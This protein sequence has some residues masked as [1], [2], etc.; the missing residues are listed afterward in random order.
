MIR[1]ERL[2]SII[3]LC[4]AQALALN[5][6]IAQ[7]AS[8]PPTA[9]QVAAAAA[10]MV[11]TDN[12]R[13]TT[14]VTV[15]NG[16]YVAGS[17]TPTAVT[18]SV[19]DATA[20]HIK[21]VSTAAD[22]N[23]L[24]VKG[25]G[26]VYT[27]SDSTI[28]LSG[29]GSNDFVGLGAGVMADANATLVMKNVNIKTA[30]VISAAMVNTN[31]GIMKVYDSTL[32]STGGPLPAGYVTKIGA[33]MMTPPSGLGIGGTARTSITLNKAES[34]FYNSTIVANGWGAL[35]TDMS[36]DYLY[37]EANNCDIQVNGNG[38]G[39]YA[40]WGSH[41][42][43]NQSKLRS[44]NF[45]G[46]IAG[47]ARLDLNDVTSESAGSLVLMHSVMG[48]VTDVGV[49][50]IHGGTHYA[51]NAAILVRSAN[52]DITVAGAKL[53]SRKGVLLQATVNPD[54]FATKVTAR[55]PG[56]RA[57]LRDTD[58]T[59]DILNDDSQRSMA[60]T[61]TG[62]KLKGAIRGATVMIDASSKWTASANS[63][64]TLV[65]NGDAARISAPKGVTVTVVAA[66]GGSPLTGVRK[67]AGG[68]TL[69]VSP[70]Q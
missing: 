60:I 29:N 44:G 35:S 18:G 15:L 63:S 49:L 3:A 56:I 64:I 24:L 30:G 69:L 23:G 67:L 2:K 25:A 52:V 38:Y 48:K 42:V 68:G 41:V 45:G 5:V 32:I 11:V 31:G 55:P 19:G 1:S 21:I 66:P 37:L 16:K 4:V 40:D 57:T 12:T 14:G 51:D 36:N 27:L 17:S 39:T 6:A 54:S 61:L 33:G 9:E 7:D 46:I 53:I 22:F 50:G 34:Y 70:A 8:A 20:S 47:A 28:E 62:T 59:G 65:N 10:A 43:I 26:S 58:L 13:Y